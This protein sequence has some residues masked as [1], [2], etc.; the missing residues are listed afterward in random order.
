MGFNFASG[1]NIDTGHGTNHVRLLASLP[2]NSLVHEVNV[3]GLAYAA[4]GAVSLTT[5]NYPSLNLS[6]GIQYGAVGHVPGGITDGTA[7]GESWFDFAAGLPTMGIIN[8][9]VGTSPTNVMERASFGIAFHWRGLLFF[10]TG[11]DLHFELGEN[12]ASGTHFDFETDYT[13]WVGYST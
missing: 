5:G 9:V 13:W 1:Q 3:Q 10:A 6:A 7:T 4:Y 12:N 11:A 8:D 2:S